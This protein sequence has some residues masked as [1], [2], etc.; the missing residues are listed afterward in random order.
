MVGMVG[1]AVGGAVILGLIESIPIALTRYQAT[2][3]REMTFQQVF[4]CLFVCL[5]VY[6]FICLFV[7]LGSRPFYHWQTGHINTSQTLEQIY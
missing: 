7:C 6:L 3:Q 2:Q 5:C 4:V 1:A